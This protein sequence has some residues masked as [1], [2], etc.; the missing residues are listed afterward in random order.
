MPELDDGAD[1]PLLRPEL[2]ELELDEPEDPELVEPEPVPVEPEPVLVEP[3][4]VLVEPELLVPDD[5]PVEPE[6][7]DD[8]EV[9]EDDVPLVCEPGSIRV[10]TPA[11]ATLA[12]LTATVVLLIRLRP[13][14]RS[15]IAR[16][17]CV[18]LRGV[19]DRQSAVRLWGT[20]LH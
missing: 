4:P 5:E 16:R 20:S 1:D 6:D 13:R 9:G 11:V 18:S 10:T 2:E 8:E 17:T 14:A 19:H 3:E 12:R 7:P 15:A